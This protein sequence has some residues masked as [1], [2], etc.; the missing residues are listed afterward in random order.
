MGTGDVQ[1]GN[2]CRQSRPKH[3]NSSE[4]PSESLSRPV[5]F[6]VHRP[7]ELWAKNRGN[8]APRGR[9]RGIYRATPL[10]ARYYR[11]IPCRATWPGSASSGN[12]ADDVGH[13][14]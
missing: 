12:V 5:F 2:L 8:T 13:G 4:S 10:V 7:T 14:E 3:R 6:R 11:A 9:L 1:L